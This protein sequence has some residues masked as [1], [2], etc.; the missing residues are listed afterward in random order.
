MYK[1]I[2]SLAFVGAVA[3]ASAAGAQSVGAPLQVRTGEVY[4]VVIEQTESGIVG[5]Q[6]LDATFRQ[7]L[8]LH[9]VDAENRLWRYTPVSVEYSLPSG[10]GVDASATSIDWRALSEGASAFLRVATDVGFECRVNEFG[11]CVE[12]S[13]WPFWRDR[14]ENFVLMFDAF[15]RMIPPA[16][17]APAADAAAP[18]KP[19]AEGEAPTANPAPAFDWAAYRGPVLRGL[20]RL[21]DGVDVRDAATLM[22]GFNPAASL[23]GRVLTRGQT[24]DIVDEAEMPFGAPP[25]RF[26]GTLRLQRIDRRNNTAIVVRRMALDAESVRASSRSIA[27]FLTTNLV[28]PI[29]AVSGADAPTAAAMSAQ[30][31]EMLN[32]LN[33]GYEET[34][35]G[36]VDLA[37][38]M[39]RETTTEFRFTMAPPGGGERE[40]I[41]MTG[42]LVMRITPGAPQVPHLPRAE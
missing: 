6:H 28:E 2:A 41:E 19:S 33:F 42:T 14:A 20:A 25:L 35:T 11:R 13:N 30:V 18:Q 37:S 27:Q 34:T 17:T 8:A 32:A 21:L 10:L 3:F 39:A 4:S 15:A 24:Q 1:S 38:G 29:S 26:A 23:Q 22:S 9:I 7:V 31:D 16:A 36:V 40:S 12:M 5:N